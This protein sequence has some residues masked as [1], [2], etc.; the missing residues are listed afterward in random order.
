MGIRRTQDRLT[1][2]RSHFGK[3]AILGIGATHLGNDS[4]IKIQLGW[5]HYVWKMKQDKIFSINLFELAEH[6]TLE[7]SSDESLSTR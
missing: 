5:G 3:V 4:V 1:S 6:Y 2:S 7:S